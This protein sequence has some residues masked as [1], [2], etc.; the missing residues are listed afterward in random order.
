MV[1]WSEKQIL[2]KTQP[3][4]TFVD[5]VLRFQIRFD[6]LGNQLVLVHLLFSTLVTYLE[7]K[8]I[9]F[10]VPFLLLF[11]KNQKPPHDWLCFPIVL[12]GPMNTYEGVV[13]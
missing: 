9:T 11:P 6:E 12:Q 2:F 4:V 3:L 1:T 5:Y 8:I 13:L 7:T 10:Y